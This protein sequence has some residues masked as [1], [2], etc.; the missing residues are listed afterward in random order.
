MTDRCLNFLLAPNHIT[1]WGTLYN[2]EPLL[3]FK[4][5]LFTSVLSHDYLI[6]FG[7]NENLVQNQLFA[8]TKL[9]ISCDCLAFSP[10]AMPPIKSP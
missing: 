7:R 3:K 8:L 4:D 9:N 10:D 2:S 1:L 5:C 6:I